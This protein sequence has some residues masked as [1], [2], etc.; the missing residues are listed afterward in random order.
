MCIIYIYLRLFSANFARVLQNIFLFPC[1][2]KA[3]KETQL[4][5]HLRDLASYWLAGEK[6]S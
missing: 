2:S 6:F 1:L 4:S 3:E 5:K